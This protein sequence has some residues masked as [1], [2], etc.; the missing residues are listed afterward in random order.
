MSSPARRGE[1]TSGRAPRGEARRAHILEAALRIVARTGPEVLTHRRVAEEAGVPLAAT[2]YWFASKDELVAEAY[3]LAA[4]RDVA[5]IGEVAADLE[6]DGLPSG[7][8]LAERLAALAARELHGER[9]SLIAGYA[10]WLEAARRPA[11]R[12]TSRA[13]TDAY[14]ALAAVMM[15]A[16]GSAHPQDDAR[17]L[18]AA[19]DGLVLEQLARDE[20]AFESD[21]LRPALARLIGALL[22]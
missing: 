13:W 19:L 16:A 12:V 4:A 2:T 20:P 22:A 15:G 7:D 3:A 9:S 11:L 5:R 10:L 21:V 1:A 8:D 6:R 18:V 14:V 17:L